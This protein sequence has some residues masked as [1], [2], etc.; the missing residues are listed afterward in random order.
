MHSSLPTNKT[1]QILIF[2]PSHNNKFHLKVALAKDLES[3]VT[4][5]S[6]QTYSIQRDVSSLSSFAIIGMS[7]T[8][9]T[10]LLIMLS[11]ST[12]I[13]PKERCDLVVND[14]LLLLNSFHCIN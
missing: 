2:I 6:I 9:T 5:Q 8:G 7:K 4:I 11:N 13:M 10:S 14:V 1:I 3:I 12:S